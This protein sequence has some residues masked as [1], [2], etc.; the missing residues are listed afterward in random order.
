MHGKDQDG[1]EQHEEYVETD[2]RSIQLKPPTD[3]ARIPGN[4]AGGLKERAN[5]E[6]NFYPDDS[7]LYRGRAKAAYNRVG[8]LHKS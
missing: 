8:D 3:P 6:G 4:S 1:A 7:V 2:V 5:K